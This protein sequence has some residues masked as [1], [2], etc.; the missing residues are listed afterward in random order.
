MVGVVL[1]EG[2][3]VARR[4]SVSA[5]VADVAAAVVVLVVVAAAS[6]SLLGLQSF[7][8]GHSLRGGD[9]REVLLR[10]QY[11]LLGDVLHL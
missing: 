6:Q 7:Q 3:R 4:G 5:V 2:W 10:S 11:S 9:Q 1:G 8:W